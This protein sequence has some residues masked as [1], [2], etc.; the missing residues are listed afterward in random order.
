MADDAG[1]GDRRADRLDRSLTVL[2]DRV[3]R[4]AAGVSAAGSGVADGY[5]PGELAQCDL[6]FPADRRAGGVRADPAPSLPVLVMVTGYSRWMT[7]RMIPSRRGPDLLAGLVAA[8]SQ[9]SAAVPRALVWDNESAVGQWRA[10]RRELTEAMQAF[11]GALGTKVVICAAPAIRR[12]RAWSSG[13][14]A[15]WR[16][17]SCPAAAFTSPADF[18]A[19]LGDWLAR[20]NQRHR[21]AL[22][23]APVDRIDADRAAMLALPPVAPSTG[24]AQLAAAAAGPLR[25][26]GRQRLLGAPGRGR[27]PRRGRRRPG[28]GRGVL[29]RA[30]GRRP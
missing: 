14:T 22:G 12:P 26:P 10:G 27:P 28:A 24:L 15:I 4:A 7:A 16:P 5:R 11:R 2:K 21:R 23:C 30:A 13:P 19:Q 3:R 8:A 20:A 18:N 9:G 25:A 29:R 6:W 17:R 1:D